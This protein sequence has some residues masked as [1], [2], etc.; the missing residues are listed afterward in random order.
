MMS[1]L[2][3]MVWSADLRDAGAGGSESE[4]SLLLSRRCRLDLDGAAFGVVGLRHR[5]VAAGEHGRRVQYGAVLDSRGAMDDLVTHR[6]GCRM[7]S[8]PSG[9]LVFLNSVRQVHRARPVLR[10]LGV[11]C[12]IVPSQSRRLA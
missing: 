11:S 3:P 7:G 1:V 9:W 10:I 5:N 2:R 4:S 8:E 6:G 12:Q